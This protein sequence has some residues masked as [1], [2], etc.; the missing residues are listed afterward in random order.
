MFNGYV[1]QMLIIINLLLVTG[2]V[3]AK[4]LSACIERSD[5]EYRQLL[6]GK[7]IGTEEVNARGEAYV[8]ETTNYEDGTLF[9]KLH[10]KT[11]SD[12]VT[13]IIRGKW[14]VAKGISYQFAT[15]TEPKELLKIFRNQVIA[16]KIICMS[17][18]KLVIRARNGGRLEYNKAL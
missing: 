1:K 18:N 12:K 9:C 3:F 11:S 4:P 6:L 16:D 14:D 8:S 7:W 17:A 15:S 13:N 10:I 5:A 2:S